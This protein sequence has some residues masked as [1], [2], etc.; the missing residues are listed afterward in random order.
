VE[1]FLVVAEL[2]ERAGGEDHPEARPAEMDISGR[3]PT[4]MLGHHSCNCVICSFKAPMMPT[5]PATT[6]A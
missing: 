3:V 1:P 5:C 6:A 4:K 2:A